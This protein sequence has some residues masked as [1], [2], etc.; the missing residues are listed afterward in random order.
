M[1]FIL[2]RSY[3][4][5]GNTPCPS[6]LKVKI[7]RLKKV[8]TDSRITSMVGDNIFKYIPGLDNS[9]FAIDGQT[10]LVAEFVYP[11]PFEPQEIS[12]KSTENGTK[13]IIKVFRLGVETASKEIVCQRTWEF[14]K[15]REVITLAYRAIFSMAMQ[16]DFSNPYG[17]NDQ[18]EDVEITIGR[19]LATCR[20]FGPN[21]VTQISLQN[22]TIKLP[23]NIHKSLFRSTAS[24][25][26]DIKTSI[27]ES[28]LIDTI[29][30]R[31]GSDI[32]STI[33]FLVSTWSMIYTLIKYLVHESSKLYTSLKRYQTFLEER[34]RP[35]EADLSFASILI[36]TIVYLVEKYLI[37]SCDY[38]NW[39]ITPTK[40]NCPSVLFNIYKELKNKYSITPLPQNDFLQTC[41]DDFEV[42]I[43]SQYDI[44]SLGFI[45]R[46]RELSDK[47]LDKT[48][49]WKK[50]VSP[51]LAC[52]Q[53]T[54]RWWVDIPSAVSSH[55]YLECCYRSITGAIPH[56]KHVDCV[57][58]S[59]PQAINL[60]IPL[61]Y[62]HMNKKHF[63]VAVLP[64]FLVHMQNE[65]LI[66]NLTKR[67]H[68]EGIEKFK[69][70]PRIYRS[71]TLLVI[72]TS[73]EHSFA[74]GE[75]QERNVGLVDL[76]ELQDP[77]KAKIKD[78]TKFTGGVLCAAVE[79]D[80]ICTLTK[81]DIK[82]P[83]T[84]WNIQLFDYDTTNGTS[85]LEVKQNLAMLFPEDL[86]Q[87]PITDEPKFKQIAAFIAIKGRW[88][89]FAIVGE[90]NTNQVFGWLRRNA[91]NILEPWKLVK[92]P[93]QGRRLYNNFDEN[94]VAFEYKGRPLLLQISSF[95]YKDIFMRI[96]TISQSRYFKILQP[97]TNINY[98]LCSGMD[99]LKLS[100]LRAYW[101]RKKCQV[102]FLYY[103]DTKIDQSMP[104]D[105]M[106][107]RGWLA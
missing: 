10:L 23:E 65:N 71:K 98:L 84:D 60:E 21:Q 1:E 96:V 89:I 7:R 74:T 22:L 85:T 90:S 19:G 14:S 70:L 42:A 106:V 100:H 8:Q 45:Q 76:R 2:L 12:I 56:Y 31:P 69:D 32:N 94:N 49:D 29:F 28:A 27:F 48:T 87:N 9:G 15:V 33:E 95:G 81:E 25:L 11:S 17:L 80:T 38:H 5:L 30:T 99:K 86:V 97:W 73:R 62:L 67:I 20:T 4:K 82:K 16:G 93:L 52:H 36:E 24:K 53:V 103:F 78:V 107:L 83:I 102:V 75:P 18:T 66:E 51:V 59:L 88:V 101:D 104:N 72:A 3:V 58:K 39:N 46:L 68:C 64:R 41:H 44:G 47:L 40:G 50:T 79:D 43:N 13:Y 55:E 77:E 92:D 35:F 91:Q 37:P 6:S 26:E 54:Q 61:K 63:G 105:L 57:S 34:E